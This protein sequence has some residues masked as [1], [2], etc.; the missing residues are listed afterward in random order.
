MTNPT[1]PT[2]RK[3]SS[4]A[5]AGPRPAFTAPALAAMLLAL[6]VATG[7][8]LTFAAKPA[9]A[10]ARAPV[11]AADTYRTLEDSRLVVPAYA[12][13]LANDRDDGKMVAKLY[14]GARNGSIALRPDGSFTYIPKANWSGTE[15]F[16]YRACDAGGLC[17]APV[18]VRIIVPGVNDVPVAGADSFSVKEDASIDVPAPGILKNDRDADGHKLYSNGGQVTAPKHGK[19][20]VRPDGSL[21]YEPAKDFAGTDTFTYRASDGYSLSE[22]ATVSMVV[23]PVDDD[24]PTA[25]DDT[26]VVAEDSAATRIDV[27]ANDTDPDAGQK[28]KV[29][30]GTAATNG[31]ASC[32]ASGCSYKPKANFAGTDFFQYVVEDPTGKR[33]T[34]TARITVTQ[35]NDAPTART[36]AYTT[37]ANTALSVAAPGLLKND[38]DPDG[39]RLRVVK[40]SQPAWGGSVYANPAGDFRFV[41]YGGYV[42]RTSFTYTVMDSAGGTSTAYAYVTVTR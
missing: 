6:L 3:T 7:S 41:P 35:V 1:P 13:V 2:L 37:R 17:S 42:G 36:D 33:A 32:D 19:A 27:L 26:A 23:T 20:I 25:T 31:Q 5:F 16:R 39:N 10:A 30:S 18:Y 29:L 8:L 15:Y 24:A 21:R 12:G 4:A 11:A 40:Y 14:Q 9:H 38:T 28:L 34:A 22:P